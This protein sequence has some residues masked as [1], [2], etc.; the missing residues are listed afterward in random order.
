MRVFEN[1]RYKQTSYSYHCLDLY[2]PD[3]ECKALLL[4]FHGGGL[5]EGGRKDVHADHPFV[6]DMIEAGFGVASADY[7]LYPDARFP[8]FIEDAAAA[9]KY[10]KE[11]LKEYGGYGKLIVG[12][13]S[14]GGYISQ[15]LCFDNKYLEA[16][17]VTQD[18]ITAYVH[19]AGQ[20]TVHFNVLRERGYDHRRIIVDKEAPLYH[21][22]L[23]KSYPP[24]QFIV[25]DNDIPNRLEQTELIVGTLRHFGY[26][27]SKVH[28]DKTSGTHVW[29]VNETDNEGKSEFG[30][31]VIPFIKSVI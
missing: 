1:I 24:M 2:L 19:D 12:G 14:A 22:G 20:P 5:I 25:S 8:D 23:S 16:V 11:S 28:L 15:M 30:N 17:G 29:Y 3:G 7:I 27:M 26:D 9:V 31:L 18:D 4:Y 21:V 6:R 10:V 13:T